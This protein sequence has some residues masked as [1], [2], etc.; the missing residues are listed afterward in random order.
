MVVVQTTTGMTE[1]EDIEKLIAA[2]VGI[3]GFV[4]AAMLRITKLSDERI[5]KVLR[6]S[7]TMM[8]HDERLTEIEKRLGVVA[9]E[10]RSG[11]LMVRERIKS[12][13]DRLNN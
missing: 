10:V 9:A 11:F 7:E 6:S 12:H 8:K 1:F 13:E 3:I 4:T 5:E 2:V